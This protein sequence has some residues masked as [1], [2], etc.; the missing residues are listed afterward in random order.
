MPSPDLLMM[1][2]DVTLNEGILGMETGFIHRAASSLFNIEAMV[3]INGMEFI[4]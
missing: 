3:I 2:F 4:E 1:M